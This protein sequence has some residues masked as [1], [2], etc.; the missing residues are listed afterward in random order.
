MTQTTGPTRTDE[1]LLYQLTTFVRETTHEFFSA[2]SRDD[3]EE[4]VRN[5]FR[6]SD[7]YTVGCII[8]SL[9]DVALAE[10]D[11]R[12]EAWTVSSKAIRLSDP[13]LASDT[14]EFPQLPELETREGGAWAFVSLEAGRTLYGGLVIHASRSDAFDEGELAAIEWFG[15]TISQAINAV[16]NRRLLF[17]NAVTEIRIDCPAT[18]MQ[19]VA[20]TAC[21][22]LSLV[23]FVPTSD[24][25]ILA[26]WDTI[27]ASPDEVENVAETIDEITASRAVG[28]DGSTVVEFVITD[29]SPLF[30]FVEGMANLS[31]VHADKQTCTVVA[32]IASG[33]CAVP[34]LARIHDYCP[35]AT[36]IAKREH[37]L[38]ASSMSNRVAL[39]TDSLD[40]LSDRQREVLEAA[41]RSGYFR[42]P[43]D[44]T[45]EE[46]AESLGISS[47]TLHKH[48]R[49]AEERLFEELFDPEA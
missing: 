27:S 35:D 17:A 38:P 10:R 28:G 44:T 37:N 2:T 20:E 15:D 49:R 25:Q 13:I 47:P 12:G 41:Y 42:W 29:G 34:T 32:E 46:V 19:T 39:P 40:S 16:E 36:L 31:A 8:D 26:Y 21:C 30:A 14:A 6:E 18:P 4:I 1:E 43:R 48:L 3:I 9:P 7:L 23:S 45:A 5:R 24:D 22:G 11:R 33:T